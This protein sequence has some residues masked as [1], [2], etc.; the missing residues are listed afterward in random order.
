MKAFICGSINWV[1]PATCAPVFNVIGRGLF[2]YVQWVI[3]RGDINLCLSIFFIEFTEL[4]EPY[5]HMNH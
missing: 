2:L 1:N 5:D 4:V 3:V